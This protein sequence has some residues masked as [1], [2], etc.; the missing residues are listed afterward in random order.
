MTGLPVA[1]DTPR[2]FTLFPPSLVPPAEQRRR[3]RVSGPRPRL[4]PAHLTSLPAADG[5]AY[6]L[7]L[8]RTLTEQAEAL[9][10]RRRTDLAGLVRAALMLLG[11]DALSQ[12]RDDDM[13]APLARVLTLP[14]GLSTGRITAALRLAVQ[15]SQPDRWQL[16]DRR[17][18]DHE[19]ARRQ[20]DLLALSS[21]LDAATAS[22]EKLAFS[23]VPGG[24]KTPRQAAYVLGIMDENQVTE[25][26]ITQRFRILA[27][28]YHPDTGLLAGSERMTQLI[29]ARRI[30]VAHARQQRG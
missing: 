7:L 19:D 29:E 1:Q 30:L 23:L 16:I 13:L 5:T 21:K 26:E 22:I 3:P 8:P 4:L 25:A 24:V 14:A 28:Q 18:R 15:L 11:D 10:S 2:Q 12:V 20:G 17:A 27:P 6:A 9:A